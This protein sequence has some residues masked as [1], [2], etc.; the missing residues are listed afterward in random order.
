MLNAVSVRTKSLLSGLYFT[1]FFRTIAHVFKLK[2]LGPSTRQ[3]L[4]LYSFNKLF[5]KSC[6]ERTFA[7]PKMTRPYF[8]LVKATLSLLGSFKKPIP[9][10][11]LLLTHDSKMKSF[12]LP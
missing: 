1:G 9:D 3:P 12:S 6:F 5:H 7:F 10:A 4:F 8:A 11:S 2:T